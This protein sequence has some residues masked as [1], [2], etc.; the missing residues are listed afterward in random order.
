MAYEPFTP[1]DATVVPLDAPD[2]GYTALYPDSAPSTPLDEWQDQHCPE[3]QS[4]DVP[5][6]GT[7]GQHLAKKSNADFDVEWVDAETGGGE[8]L[9]DVVGPNAAI[10]GNFALFDGT[11][12][13]LI[14]DGAAKPADF[15][16]K[17]GGTM[18]GAITLAADPVSPLQAATKQY[19]DNAAANL[20][21][22]TNT[23]R[24][25]IAAGT[26]VGQD[27]T[28]AQVATMLPVFNGAKGLVPATGGATSNRY[29]RDD[30]TWQ[31]LASDTFET[32]AALAAAT[33]TSTT[34]TIRRFATG[35]VLWPTKYRRVTANPGHAL[36]GQD[37]AGNWYEV[38][39]EVV[40]AYS[41]GCMC[42][43][44]GTLAGGTDDFANFRRFCTFLWTSGKKGTWEGGMRLGNADFIANGPIM[45]PE[46]I[47]NF[48]L[49]GGSG[50]SSYLYLHGTFSD[51][52]LI[53]QE[54]GGIWSGSNLSEYTSGQPPPP[55]L[56][57]RWLRLGYFS[58]FGQNV[59][60]S[61]NAIAGRQR[62]IAF[63]GSHDNV[64]M[65]YV[66][67]YGITGTA[68]HMGAVRGSDTDG[69]FRESVVD[70]VFVKRCGWTDEYAWIIEGGPVTYGPNFT[71][72]YYCECSLSYGNALLLRNQ[73]VGNNVHG[74]IFFGLKLHGTGIDTGKPLPKSKIALTFEGKC[75]DIKMI[76]LRVMQH[77]TTGTNDPPYGP[78]V[79]F[80]KNTSGSPEDI[81][82]DCAME[83]NQNGFDIQAGGNIS[84][85]VRDFSQPD[86]PDYHFKLGPDVIRPI[87]V[88]CPAYPKKL[89]Y[90][91]DAAT[92]RYLVLEK[93]LWDHEYDAPAT[94]LEA[95][96]KDVDTIV[97]NSTALV[98]ISNFSATLDVGVVY[99]FCY[100]VPFSTTTAA[101]FQFRINTTGGAITE[102]TC[103]YRVQS[104]GKDK[105][106][107]EQALTLNTTYSV[108][109]GANGDGWV[110]A[111]GSFKGVTAA[112]TMTFRFAQATATAVNTIAFKGARLEA[113]TLTATAIIP[114]PA[115]SGVGDVTGPGSAV[116]QRV[117]IFSGT[118][119]KIIA[120]GGKT[121]S[122][123]Q[124]VVTSSVKGLAP[125]SGGG[126][127]NFLRADGNW[128]APPGGGT[129]DVTG[130]A[131]SVVGRVATFST[132]TGKAI[133]DGG[134]LLSS[135]A[136][137]SSL[138]AI[139][140]SGSAT[141][142]I[143]GTVPSARLP[144]ALSAL[145]GLP[146]AADRMAYYTG[147]GTAAIITLSSFGR[148]LIDDADAAAGQA[149]LGVVIGTNVQAWSTR[150]DSV[151]GLSA[152]SGGVEK[153]G[154]NTFG[155]YTLTTFA[156]TILDDVDA[157]TVRATIGAGTG[158][159]DVVGPASSVNGRVATFNGT[160][161][162]LIQDGG[163]LLSSL[164][165][166]SSLAAIATSGSAS[167]LSAGTVPSARLPAALSALHGL[168]PAADK[169]AYYDSAST[170]VLITLSA[171]ARTLL[172]D[173][174]AAAVRATIGAGTGSGDVT[175]PASSVSGRIATFSGTTGKIIQDGG[176]LVADL[177]ALSGAT[178]TGGVAAT[179][180]TANA[181]DI[182][183]N[184]AGDAAD[185]IVDIRS[186]TGFG[187]YLQFRTGTS[188]RWQAGVGATAETG[189][190]AGAN[191]Y[192]AAYS[193][194][195][196]FL[197]FALNIARA[198]RIVDF[199]VSPTVPTPTAGDN[200]T[201]VAST[202]FVAT[203]L[204][205]YTPS[206]SLAAVATSGSASDLGTGTLPIAR[207]ADG[208]VTN[209]KLAQVTGPVLKGRVTATL[210]D[211]ADLTPTQTTAM[212]D[213]FTSALKGLA[214][215]SGGGSTNF[216]RADGAWAA[217]P[218]GGG[219]LA[220]AYAAITD[221]TT[222]AT[223]SG[224][225]T[226]KLRSADGSLS[227]VTQNNDATHGDN[228]NIQIPAGAITLAKM[229]NMNT[230][231]LLGR[232]TAG[233][234]APEEI[235]LDATLEWT[236]SASI[237]RAALTG[238][239]TATAG[240][241]ATTIAAAAVT[242]A[243]MA[244]MATQ[245]IKGRT[246][247]GSGAPEDLTAT[248]AT[249]ILDVFTSTLKGLAPSSG[250]GTTTFLRADG[251]WA[252]PA[253]GGDVVGPAG[254]VGDNIAV[255]NSTTGKLIKDGGAAISSLA[256][257]AALA[258]YLPLTGGTLSGALTGQS[259]IITNGGFLQVDR[260]GD[261]AQAFLYIG[262]D[263]GQ[264]RNIEFRS[265]TSARFQLRI[266]NV[267]EAGSNVGSNMQLFAYD[268]AGVSLG[269]VYSINRAS[270]VFDFTVSPT[271]PTPVATDN[272]QTLA[273]TAY[274]KN[275]LG[276]A[277]T[278]ITYQTIQ[279]GN[280]SPAL[281]I[282]PTG[283]VG[284]YLQIVGKRSDA[285][286][287]SNFGG[288]VMLAK[289][290]IDA[291]IQSGNHIG[292]ILFG[293]PADFTI[294][295]TITASA[296][297]AGYA[298]GAWTTS[299]TPTGL[300]FYVGSTPRAANAS[301]TPGDTLAL[302]I[303]DTGIANFPLSPTSVT[304]TAGD[305]S[306]KL[307]TTAFV[308][309]ADN[310]KANLAS[311][312]FTGIPA[313]PTASPGTNTTQLATTAYVDAAATLD[314]TRLATL[315]TSG[316]EVASIAALRLLTSAD[317][318]TS[319]SVKAYYPWP[320]SKGGGW[321]DLD[322]SDTTTADDSFTCIVD[323][324][325]PRRG[326]WKR[327]FENYDDLFYK[328]G[329]KGDAQFSGS[330]VA[331]INT[332]DTAA[333]N[334]VFKWIRT[335]ASTTGAD[336]SLFYGNSGAGLFG[337]TAPVN[338]TKI[339]RRWHLD[340]SGAALVASIAPINGNGRIA[341]D[342]TACDGIWIDGL[343]VAGDITS[344][345]EPAVLWELCRLGSTSDDHGLKRCKSTG[346]ALW[347][348]MHNSGGENVKYDQCEW[349]NWFRNTSNVPL[350]Y[351]NAQDALT[352]LRWAPPVTG[353]T[354]SFATGSPA[355]FT[356]TAHPLLTGDKL[357][358]IWSGTGKPTQQRY[359]VTKT[360]ANTFTLSSNNVAVADGGDG[361]STP[362]NITTASPNPGI[363]YAYKA[364]FFSEF[365]ND[366]EDTITP[367][368]GD[369]AFTLIM[370][371]GQNA[372]PYGKAAL[373][374]TPGGR[375]EYSCRVSSGIHDWL[376][377]VEAT[378]TAATSTTFTV[379]SGAI[380]AAGDVVFVESASNNNAGKLF[381]I[382]SIATNVLTMTHIDGY[383]APGIN[384]SSPT[385]N[386]LRK[387]VVSGGHGV[388]I[389]SSGLH[390]T[391]RYE[392]LHLEGGVGDTNNPHSFF[393]IQHIDK[394]RDASAAAAPVYFKGIRVRDHTPNCQWYM[395]ELDPTTVSWGYM[396]GEVT[397][398][399]LSN[400]FGDGVPAHKMFYPSSTAMGGN[401]W[402]ISGLFQVDDVA[403]STPI[404]PEIDWEGGQY[405]DLA[406]GAVSYPAP[407][408]APA[409]TAAL[410][411]LAVG[412]ANDGI[413][414]VAAGQLGFA[415]GGSQGFMA[416]ANGIGIGG[417]PS[418][419][420][421]VSAN[422]PGG[423][424]ASIEING[425]GNT[426]LRSARFSS[427]SAAPEIQ[428]RK[429][430]GTIALPTAISV[431]DRAGEFTTQAYDGSAY[432]TVSTERATVIAS[433]PSSTDMQSRW[434][435]QLNPA[436]S[437]TQTEILRLEHATG[438]S[439]FGANPV[440]DQNRLLVLR[441]YT[442][443]SQPS[444]SGNA[445]KKIF[446]SDYLGGVEVVSD[447]TD[448]V[449]DV[450]TMMIALSDEATAIT[451][452]TAKVTKRMPYKGKH[453]KIPRAE[454]NTVSSSGL[455]TF[456]IN[457]AGTSILGANKLTIDASEK[458]SA[459]AATATTLATA[460]FA[461]DDEYT[462][463]I[464]VAGTGAKGAKVTMYLKHI[465]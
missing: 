378:T 403:L 221:G 241:N 327:R 243:K 102:Q 454:L 76:G 379:P 200:T 244:N 187:R 447:G 78:A 307:A 141:D 435:L 143:A 294:P 231:R 5:P 33:P 381:R 145:H 188:Q 405:I 52:F 198:S 431:N 392:N 118:S 193:D 11:T 418:A 253:G 442:L 292:S 369:G 363:S 211:L 259:N 69:G 273:T 437:V 446:V 21:V 251:T 51:Y 409:G 300:R 373:M 428:A 85:K 272:T 449:V 46:D 192:V 90:V 339:S 388:H 30:G 237:R 103:F 60:S 180:L 270:R 161:G 380:W 160:T 191:L 311:P 297:I 462:F 146:P 171:F 122:D 59:D 293:G 313:A 116:D 430:R 331:T 174:D 330:Y 223:A 406:T 375:R 75:S 441:S 83:A 48:H 228:A 92:S 288:R 81:D 290:R 16:A 3:P 264:N 296:N 359:T 458:T 132:I 341:F 377:L 342:L 370:N 394:L 333:L 67:F 32:L 417:S 448:W 260:A 162:K 279:T 112:S 126:T 291:A 56:D 14:K 154:A 340:C 159:G 368:V 387:Q 451:T 58:V 31:S 127:T 220:D 269:T 226:F 336:A 176:V 72:F 194:A 421:L 39:E 178:F 319:V 305:S 390:E 147:A 382:A 123:L 74:L 254:A 410:P 283:N 399:D 214:P 402:T 239:V 184:R 461:D 362:L 412:A 372:A 314:R 334:R 79:Q 45:V 26:G 366:S 140:T 225:T 425:E 345:K 309:T 98:S 182:L 248:Q 172:D 18:T 444:A 175:G 429:A 278:W 310:L 423:G 93:A 189:S 100:R 20:P 250:G 440:F 1:R 104:P 450:E 111:Y 353:A 218:G 385:T 210:G 169:L 40:N 9:G 275:Q 347:A 411:G 289:Q 424:A 439:M 242:N 414:R 219:G 6:G 356:W 304:P 222:P 203:A 326:T 99:E 398:A 252:A 215:A 38:A 407:I 206:T 29:L 453:A 158:S 329:A 71:P 344:G 419:T 121:V 63:A 17:T 255:F 109:I 181:G 148:S 64:C 144:A 13:K 324:A 120:D 197:G 303:P 105:A 295:D 137:T 389:I 199:P 15:L 55:P 139:A 285:N 238:D 335:K 256:T 338:A 185:A 86:T 41:A 131:S 65:E 266:N 28:P 170:A 163:V 134:V 66:D 68:L 167:D 299:L 426:F 80:K 117:A 236:G 286:G 284:A 36:A 315:E 246:T 2:E 88:E 287:A 24:G 386:V 349:F 357:Y 360:G 374:D 224:S 302:E 10:D 4:G 227:I 434:E 91:L 165:L 332:D 155:T 168:T 209:A 393:Y 166:T 106:D 152:T 115:P 396:L 153:T 43:H 456:D 397:V 376:P 455:P 179:T 240:S 97:N 113:K 22:P 351:G 433:T 110:E 247:A 422:R 70:H 432:Q 12:G 416:T 50:R 343:G 196:A 261:A 464:D 282:I 233:S 96:V 57:L 27:L 230:D 204:G 316:P 445:G 401:K 365:V 34:I 151:A 364:R 262:A 202:A 77:G 350:H 232:D 371:G 352:Y 337:I 391:P 201:K 281:N 268:D 249:A 328:A 306:T 142:L 7:A 190:N 463:D 95:T 267:A 367:Y 258:G 47:A 280:A 119:G 234:G 271:A 135:L 355:V 361:I 229:A 125:A 457:L 87:Y 133:Q 25:R 108:P 257:N 213:V 84:I 73:Q 173:A 130:P 325:S 312:T 465:L 301:L 321:F 54:R 308:T 217:P 413:Y 82:I 408:V 164:A 94:L 129:G 23:I 156:K 42:D 276:Q 400:K 89:S 438:L 460:A 205:S 427:G 8:T 49:V 138:A 37:A 53:F 263:A 128:A 395:F 420:V 404:S 354:V 61:G 114:A 207:I 183:L 320:F 19:A 124:A 348:G 277:N 383:T 195:G 177:A 459:T 346:A 358:I 265:G 101:G 136:Q 186:D 35:K 107:V 208:A 384:I 245:T 149:T 317:L 323:A 150:L 452:G 44:D 298:S 62:G 443:G 274:V 157:A 322:T 318:R 216:L 436:G 235:S 415:C 212:L